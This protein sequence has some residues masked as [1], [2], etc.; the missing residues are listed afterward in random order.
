MGKKITGVVPRCSG[1]ME[2]VTT[3]KREKEIKEF[4]KK[5]KKP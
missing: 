2:L 5:L 3:E 1:R 4:M